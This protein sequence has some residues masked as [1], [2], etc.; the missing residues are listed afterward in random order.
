MSPCLLII[1]ALLAREAW[2]IALSDLKYPMFQIP[3]ESCLSEVSVKWPDSQIT[4][5]AQVSQTFQHPFALCQPSSLSLP[6]N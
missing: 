1:F 3:Q 2:P 6:T 5:F 4:A